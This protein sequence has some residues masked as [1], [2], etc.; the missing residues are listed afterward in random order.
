MR[1]SVCVSERVRK[2]ES[3]CESECMSESVCESGRSILC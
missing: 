3:V 1:G 2:R